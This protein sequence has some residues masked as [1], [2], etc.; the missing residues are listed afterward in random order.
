MSDLSA[1]IFA[2]DDIVS[3]VV[4]VPQ[5]GVTVEVRSMTARDRSRL[6][7]AAA[8]DGG[9]VKFEEVLPDVVILCTFDPETGERVFSENDREALLS[10]AAGAIE[11]LAT[12]ALGLSGMDDN[13]MDEAGKDS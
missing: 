4:P 11:M 10:K 5:W 12:V 8:M 7:S 13:A 6:L 2:A 9:V 3:K 1:K